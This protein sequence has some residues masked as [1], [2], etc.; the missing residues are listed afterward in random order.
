MRLHVVPLAVQ[1]TA[2]GTCVPAT[3]ARAEIPSRCGLAWR[4]LGGA[5]DPV[6]GGETFVEATLSLAALLGCV[7]STGG[8]FG[9]VGTVLVS[10]S[11]EIDRHRQR[12]I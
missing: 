4:N 11:L 9:G 7:L 10:V 5:D 2:D 1:S 12:I 8:L 3:L 6:D